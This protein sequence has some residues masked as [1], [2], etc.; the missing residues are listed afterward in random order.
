MKLES[1]VES[2]SSLTSFT[3]FTADLLTSYHGNTIQSCFFVFP[4]GPLN[5]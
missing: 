5:W 2:T 1:D 3:A 4:L